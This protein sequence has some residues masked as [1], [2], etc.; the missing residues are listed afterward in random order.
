MHAQFESWSKQGGA[1]RTFSAAQPIEVLE[2][3]LLEEA[4]ALVQRAKVRGMDGLC[5]T[6]TSCKRQGAPLGELW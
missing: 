6:V 5:D 1:W 4:M 3:Q 2:S